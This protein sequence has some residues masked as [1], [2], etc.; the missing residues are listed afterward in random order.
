MVFEHRIHMWTLRA[1]VLATFASC[2]SVASAA[3]GDLFMCTDSKGKTITSDRP[4]PECA[5]R[6][7]KELRSDGS[8]RRVIEPPPTAEQRAQKAAED[9]R[10]AEEEG[11]R[12]DQARRDRALLE[13]Y[14]VEQDIEQARVRAVENRRTI[15][16]R[17][18]KRMDELLRERK[19]L[20]SE[21]EFFAKREQPDKLKRAYDTNAGMIQGQEKII[22]DT[23]AEMKRINDRFE[24]ERKRFRELV[25]AG[26]KPAE[27]SASS[28][29]R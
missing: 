27:R 15:L 10:K 9:R 26:A 19:K 12:R 11:R 4:P 1:L 17:A 28:A 29:T 20:D 18:R 25:Q 5:D 6:P 3:P 2:A 22:A 16:D 13:A 14:A 21:A 7:I 23:E 8:L 24:E